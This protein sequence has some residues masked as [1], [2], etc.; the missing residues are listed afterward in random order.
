MLNDTVNL[1]IETGT[2]CNAT[3]S[4]TW[5]CAGHQVT[6]SIYGPEESKITD[7]L[8]HRA[9]VD[10]T[11]TPRAGLRTSKEAELEVYFNSLIERLIDVKDF[12]RCKFIGRLYIVSGQTND[13][14]T[15][16]AAIN[17]I[18][19]S[20]LVSHL[21]LRATIAA[22][23]HTIQNTMITFAIDVTHPKLLMRKQKTAYSNV[24]GIFSIY[25][26]QQQQCQIGSGVD[27]ADSND[28]HPLAGIPV[29]KLLQVIQMP[30][31]LHNNSDESSEND[32]DGNIYEQALNLLDAMVSQ[33]NS[34]S[35]I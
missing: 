22:I 20:L 27:E 7:E 32:G 2:D 5:D 3:G 35:H 25:T 11:V 9:T 1:F 24:P 14:R 8:T 29:E 10:V 6:F 33:I 12:P 15:V 18:S 30:K 23:C 13:C 17:A 26:G 16:A 19:L 28:E 34:S 31:S 4:A 21:P